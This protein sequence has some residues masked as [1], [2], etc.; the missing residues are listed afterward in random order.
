MKYYCYY[1]SHENPHSKCERGELQKLFYSCF[2]GPT[3][4]LDADKTC[5]PFSVALSHCSS[6]VLFVPHL[7][8]ATHVR[9]AY[10]VL[11]W[12]S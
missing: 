4:Q 3:S 7:P 8:F 5:A 9:D 10:C 1:F 12:V 2:A 6:L 11:I